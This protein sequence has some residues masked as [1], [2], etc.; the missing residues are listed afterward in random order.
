VRRKLEQRKPIIC[1]KANI[2]DPVVVDMIGLFGF[3]C[4]W[5]CKEH[6]AIDWDRLGHLI[7]TASMNDMDAVVRVPKG[8]YSDLIRPLEL[9][10]AGIMVPHCKDEVEAQEIAQHTRFYPI[11]RRPLDGGNS[12][13][14]YTLTPIAD[15]LRAANQNTLVIVQIEDPE[16]FDRI[17]KI[18]AVAGIDVLFVGPADLSQGLGVPGQQD[19]PEIIKVIARVAEACRKFAK[20]WGLPVTTQSARKY[21]DMGATFLTCGA[22]VIG[23]GNYYRQLCKELES[24]GV[25]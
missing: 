21:M 25:E 19:H 18:A 11:G 5:I 2:F 3:D 13:A 20:S 14:H 12:D 9:G 4:V 16:A 23:L 7:R 17:E 1:T 24:L 8:S 22:D 15:Y 6:G 10:C